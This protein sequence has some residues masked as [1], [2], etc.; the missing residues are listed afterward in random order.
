MSHTK[1]SNK[2]SKSTNAGGSANV[3]PNNGGNTSEQKPSVA[4]PPEP[5]A[6]RIIAES[7]VAPIAV[8]ILELGA[9]Q[10]ISKNG[11]TR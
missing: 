2:K 10:E 3:H 6:N 7:R 5:P 1:S 11:E 9:A 4:K 8:M